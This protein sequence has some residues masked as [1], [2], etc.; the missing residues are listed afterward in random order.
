MF[1]VRPNVS[2]TH[3]MIISARPDT[4]ASTPEISFV[5]VVV[6]GGGRLKVETE[7]RGM[8][9]VGT[10]LTVESGGLILADNVVI[11]TNTLTVED[12]GHISADYQVRHVGRVVWFLILSKI[13]F[14]IIC[15]K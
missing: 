13:H 14:N 7:G 9:L 4:T 15:L 1:T 3:Y 12:S 10:T 5:S 2:V 8:K 11:E 6:Q